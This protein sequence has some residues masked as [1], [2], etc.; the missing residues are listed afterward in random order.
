M[1]IGRADGRLVL[2]DGDAVVDVATASGGEFGPD[3]DRVFAVWDRFTAWASA[4]ASAR[5]HTGPL[6]AEQLGAPVLAP[7]QVFGI[8]LNYRE[9]AAESGVEAPDVPPVFTKFPSCLTGPYAAV[10]LPSDRVDWEVELVV[11]MGRR[12]ER[13]P[14]DK[15]WSYVAGL[16]T[17]QDLSER[18]V[19]LAGPVPQF[20]LGKSFPGFGPTGPWLVT[21]DELADR[22]DLRLSCSVDGRVRQDGRTRDMIFSVPELVARISAVCPLLPG[23]LIFTGTPSGVG[24]GRKPPEYLRPGTTLVSAIEGLGELR[25]PLVAGPE[26]F[27]YGG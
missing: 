11:V 12:A 5:A 13:V 21:P 8:G 14:Q 9:H 19:Q 3:P 18:T 23:D 17:G 24:M 22:D 10:E 20:S 2:I 25:N 15:G 26:F 27:S 6:V 16:M 4:P 1:R 7:S